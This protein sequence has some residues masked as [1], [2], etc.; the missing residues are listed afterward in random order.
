MNNVLFRY[1]YFVPLLW[2]CW[3]K[4]FLKEEEDDD[5]EEEVMS[6]CC[7]LVLKNGCDSDCCPKV[8][9]KSWGA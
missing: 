4:A 3:G 7:V 8:E 9:E 2:L 6:V 5:E 1:L